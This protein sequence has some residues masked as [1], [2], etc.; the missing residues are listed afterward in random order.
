M[1]KKVVLIACV[2]L[3]ALLGSALAAEA[4]VRFSFGVGFGRPYYG[5]CSYY[6]YHPG[7]LYAPYPRYAYRP[8]YAPP[9]IYRTPA[10]GSPYVPYG[11]RAYRYSQPYRAYG[12]RP[13]PRP[14]RR[15]YIR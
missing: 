15:T 9:V 13:Y 14:Y 4:R 12:P 5:P 3:V 1:K 6:S 11:Y 10:I 7:Y 8:Y 2:S